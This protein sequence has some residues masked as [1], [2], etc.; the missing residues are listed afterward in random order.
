MYAGIVSGGAKP[1]GLPNVEQNC[2]QAATKQFMGVCFQC[3][4]IGHRARDCPRRICFQ[5]QQHGHY[6]KQCP[7][8]QAQVESCLVC[9]TQGV[10]F[11]SCQNC[12]AIRR[13]LESSAWRA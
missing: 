7:L 1:V 5:C 4:S 6:A 10:N 2:S 11:L 9:K 3:Q 12:V 13:V 8:R